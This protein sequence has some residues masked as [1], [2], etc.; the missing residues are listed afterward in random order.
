LGIL[1]AILYLILAASLG[2]NFFYDDFPMLMLS[3]TVALIILTMS[4]YVILRQDW[5]QNRQEIASESLKSAAL[6]LWLLLTIGAEFAKVSISGHHSF[7][8]VVPMTFT[9]VLATYVL[10][11]DILNFYWKKPPESWENWL[12][13]FLIGYFIVQYITTIEK[14]DSGIHLIV[15]I[16]FA[17]IATLLWNRWRNRARLSGEQ[18]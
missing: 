12:R 5:H 14:L 7:E 15:G 4:F 2:N 9:S 18:N 10:I 13:I 16:S 11:G 17:T 8:L 6:T 1:A 3:V